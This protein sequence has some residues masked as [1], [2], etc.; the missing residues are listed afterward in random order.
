MKNGIGK[1]YFDETNLLK[2]G[3]PH[4]QD[5][6]F[7]DDDPSPPQQQEQQQ[8][9]EAPQ[10]EEPLAAPEEE[11]PVE[12]PAVAPPKISTLAQEFA[13]WK[14]ETGIHDASLSEYN[15]HKAWKQNLELYDTSLLDL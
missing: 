3:A 15:N 7:V 14:R 8:Q 2:Q 9:E 10:Q 4:Q 12:E 5:D 1:I 13:E 11:P 6:L